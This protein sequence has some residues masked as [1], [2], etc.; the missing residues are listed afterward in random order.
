[1]S[2]AIKA[3]LLSAFVF[4]G[5]GH[6]YLKKYVTGTLLAGIALAS[7]YLMISRMVERALLIVDKIQSGEV[8]LD[9]T[10]IAELLSK[11]PD[12]TDTQLY[13]ITW[14]LFIFSWFIAVADSYRIG[15]RQDKK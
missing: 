6:F 14:T 12:G 2:K 1:M 11:Q 15:R 10:A 4:P 5:T 3:A 7:L 9:I 13:I 8:P